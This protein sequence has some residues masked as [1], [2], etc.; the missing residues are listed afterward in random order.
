M[1]TLKLKALV[2]VAAISTTAAFVTHASS[3]SA[4]SLT[5]NLNAQ[6]A[7]GGTATGSFN[8]DA[9]SGV[10]SQFNIKT[11]AGT[12]AP[13]NFLFPGAT[14]TAASST[15]SLQDSI[16]LELIGSEFSFQ[17]LFSAPLT[18]AGGT[19]SL[20]PSFSFERLPVPGGVG[21]IRDLASGT[22]TASATAV[23]T[24]ALLPG[25]I[26]LGLGVLRQKRK[27]AQAK[28]LG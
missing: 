1:M 28:T 16:R 4:A 6:F 18:E 12:S 25:L 7:G 8:Y 5:W 23:P 13:S 24:P 26:G 15:G 10:L 17:T 2:T 9:T 19:I 3:A 22:V 20:V 11:L 27:A 21:I 14:Y